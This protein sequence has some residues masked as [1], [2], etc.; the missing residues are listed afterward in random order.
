MRLRGPPAPA[1][2]ARARAALTT[3]PGLL[4]TLPSE[5]CACP[6]IAASLLAQH[7]EEQLPGGIVHGVSTRP[8]GRKYELVKA[9]G[10]VPRRRRPVAARPQQR[11][12]CGRWAQVRVMCEA[13][14]AG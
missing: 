12:V 3:H 11:A 13:R 6:V 5:L 10:R 14:A 9:A 4:S 8:R 7:G 2:W 1:P